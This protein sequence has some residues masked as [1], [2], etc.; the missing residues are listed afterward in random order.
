MAAA[1]RVYTIG[2]SNRPLNEFIDLLKRYNIRVVVD[3]RRFPKSARYPYYNREVLEETLENEGISYVWLGELLGG[4]RSGGYE[5]YM[6]TEGYREGIRKLVEI[7]ERSNKHVAIMCSERLWFRCH[8]RFIANTLVE[9]GYDVIHI[10]DKDKVYV[11]KRQKRIN[12]IRQASQ[13]DDEP[14]GNLDITNA[15]EPPYPN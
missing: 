9:L 15:E 12:Q 2:H 14:S 3:V 6:K 1:K 10:I 13:G 5:E 8:R 7:I 4:Y 11:H